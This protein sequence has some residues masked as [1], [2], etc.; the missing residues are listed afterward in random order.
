MASATCG[1]SIEIR[2]RVAA[3]DDARQALS[4]TVWLPST[5]PALRIWA[6]PVVWDVME[7]IEDLACH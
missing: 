4:D 6:P 7:A 1:A 2:S 3:L 5:T